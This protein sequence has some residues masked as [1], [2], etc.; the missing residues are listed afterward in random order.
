MEKRV[1]QDTELSLQ[2]AELIREKLGAL[3]E[4][5]NE[6]TSYLPES[7]DW[8]ELYDILGKY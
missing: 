4:L 1:G 6:V 7:S 3:D 2:E 8:P 5:T